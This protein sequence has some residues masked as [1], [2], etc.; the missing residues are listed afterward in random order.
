MPATRRAFLIARDPEAPWQ[1][2]QAP[3]MPR[4]GAP[5]NSSYSNR[6]LSRLRLPAI[7]GPESPGRSGISRASSSL[8]REEELDGPLAGLEQDVAHEP[9]ADDDP[10]VAIVDVAALDVA[11][12]PRRPGAGLIE[13]ER[14]AGQLGPLLVLRADVQQADSGRVTPRISSA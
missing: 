10:H 8:S 3:R 11:H 13:V 5:P 4:S 7:F 14:V 2:M 9:V 6:V 1:M 12:E